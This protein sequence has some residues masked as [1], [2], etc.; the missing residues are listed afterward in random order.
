MIRIHLPELLRTSNINEEYVRLLA[1]AAESVEGPAQ[2][3]S[4]VEMSLADPRR[5][6]AS[7]RHVADD[8][9][10]RP[11][12]ATA[13]AVEELYRTMELAPVPASYAVRDEASLSI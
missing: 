9:F 2:A 1:D 11:G 13:R 8:L 5:R 4:A 10:Y 7:R 3:L 6:S 12:T